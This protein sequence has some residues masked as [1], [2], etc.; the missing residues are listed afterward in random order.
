[1]EEIRAGRRLDTQIAH[2]VFGT[3]IAELDRMDEVP[4]YSRDR[5]L[6]WA[7][8]EQLKKRVWLSCGCW[9]DEMPDG[10]VSYQCIVS[11]GDRERLRHREDVIEYGRFEALAICRALLE[12]V[13]LEPQLSSVA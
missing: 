2:L 8:V 6:A 1:M 4:R 7:A 3:P 13:N 10:R 5:V 12:V 9:R 11:V